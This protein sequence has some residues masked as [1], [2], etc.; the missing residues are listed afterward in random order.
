MGKKLSTLFS[1]K[2]HSR[3]S[4]KFAF[5]YLPEVCKLAVF[6]FLSDKEKAVAAQ[7]CGEWNRLMRSASLW[8]DVDFLQFTLCANSDH[9]TSDQRSGHNC[10]DLCYKEYQKKVL[11]YYQYL[12]NIKPIVKGLKFAFDIGDYRDCWLELIQSF[13]ETSRCSELQSAWMNWKQTPTK[14]VR[15]KN[16]T[17]CTNDYNEV[18]HRH[19]HRQRLFVKFFDLFTASAPNVSHLVIPFDWS[20]RSVQLLARLQNIQTLV[21]DKYFVY[22]SLEQTSLNHL[23]HSLP[24]LRSLTLEVW[25]PSGSGLLFYS[26]SSESLEYVDISKCRGFYLGPVNLPRVKTLKASRHLWNGPLVT[27]DSSIHVPC[28]HQVLSDGSPILSILND[29]RLEEEW[30]TEVSE[31]LDRLLK[32]VCSCCMHMSEWSV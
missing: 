26:I 32:T 22:Q 9:I 25:T 7:V 18:I 31:E 20:E 15:P 13:L 8:C 11:M 14:P 21:L 23:I 16:V 3:S 2:E 29:H 24:R 30:R 10:D 27:R 28:I 4:S 6:S 19:R 17:W 12:L 1:K 5:S